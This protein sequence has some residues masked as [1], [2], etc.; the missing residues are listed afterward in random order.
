LEAAAEEGDIRALEKLARLYESGEHKLSVN[1]SKQLYRALISQHRLQDSNKLESFAT[2]SLLHARLAAMTLKEVV[3]AL[4]P[5]TNSNLSQD[6]SAAPKDESMVFSSNLFFLMYEAGGLCVTAAGNLGACD[7]TALWTT[8]GTQY[9]NFINP[10][11]KSMC[12]SVVANAESGLKSLVVDACSLPA[13]KGWKMDGMKLFHGEHGCVIR[14]QGHSQ[15]LLQPCFRGHTPL[16]VMEVSLPGREGFLLQTQDGRC[17]NG[18]DF[19]S[20]DRPEAGWGVVLNDMAEGGQYSFYKAH[21][22]FFG[23]RKQCL[24]KQGMKDGMQRVG[25][26]ICTTRSAMRWKLKGGYLIED[27]GKRCLGIGLDG[28][29]VLVSMASCVPLALLFME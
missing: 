7:E 24:Q 17:F 1:R 3:G 18:E 9:I 28:S 5:R 21:G 20:C 26:G 29:P 11:S 13:A 2:Q 15:L 22:G 6:P 12:L 19:S 8:A 25:L 27:Q 10:R 16:M 23:G 4:W 14:G